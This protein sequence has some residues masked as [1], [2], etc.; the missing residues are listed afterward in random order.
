MTGI[1]ASTMAWTVWAMPGVPPSSLIAEAPVSF[2]MRPAL[3]TAS[4]VE[5]W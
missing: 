4:S 5:T 1:P 3:R 2:R